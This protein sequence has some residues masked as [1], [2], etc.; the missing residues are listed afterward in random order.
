MVEAF[1]NL[2]PPFSGCVL[3]APLEVSSAL[4][5]CS[6]NSPFFQTRCSVLLADGTLARLAFARR[7]Q[8]T[9]ANRNAVPSSL[10]AS[11]APV[12]SSPLLTPRSLS[13][14]SLLCSLSLCLSR[15]LPPVDPSN[16]PNQAPKNPQRNPYIHP[17]PPC[18]PALP[19]QLFYPRF[20][21]RDGG[22]TE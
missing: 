18:I 11:F 21:A 9:D 15:R 2:S 16:S 14:F 12:F 19:F 10:H 22:D 7:D 5:D 17:A 6:P 13:L 1:R 8:F 20:S 4:G 3:V